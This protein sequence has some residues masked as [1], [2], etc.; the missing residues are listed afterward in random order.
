MAGVPLPT[1]QAERIVPETFA[2]WMADALRRKGLTQE[3]AARQ[4]GVSVKTVNRWVGGET[5]PRFRDLRRIQEKF[6]DHPLS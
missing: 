3:E 4:L 1:P 2:G 5:E 6:G